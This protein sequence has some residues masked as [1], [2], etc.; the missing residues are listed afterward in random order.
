MMS[1][2][3]APEQ[4]QHSADPTNTRGT[5]SVQIQLKYTFYPNS[6]KNM[7]FKSFTLRQKSLKNPFINKTIAK[8]EKLTT[9]VTTWYLLMVSMKRRN[10]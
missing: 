6:N 7:S 9:V 3:A 1:I 5:L 2:E 10:Y 4:F 8:R